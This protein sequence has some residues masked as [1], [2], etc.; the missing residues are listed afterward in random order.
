MTGLLISRIG[1]VKSAVFATG[2]ICAGQ[3]ILYLGHSSESVHVMALGIF[4]F[5]LTISPL[6]VCQESL[7]FHLWT[8]PHSHAPA[9]GREVAQG[10]QTGHGNTNLLLSL[11]LLLGKFSSFMAALTTVPLAD[12]YGDDAPFSLS[13]TFCAISFALTLCLY[14]GERWRRRRHLESQVDDVDLED[15]EINEE[16]FELDPERMTEDEAENRAAADISAD[17]IK[18]SME[19]R[20]KEKKKIKFKSLINLGDAFWWYIF[21]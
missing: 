21:V 16:A 6:S 11:A 17:V 19:E 18:L 14:L 3:A 4:L 20:V 15:D 13:F 1:V 7:I 5:G 9:S 2:I 12:Q 8:S 10:G